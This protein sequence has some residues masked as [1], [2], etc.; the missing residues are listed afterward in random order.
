MKLVEDLIKNNYLLTPSAYY[1]LAP[2][3]EN[4][5]FTL[6]E[7]VKFAK[8][9]GTFVIDEGLAEEFI[10]FKGLISSGS[11]EEH[12]IVEELPVD[13][14]ESGTGEVAPQEKELLMAE[15]LGVE[16]QPI[17]VNHG[18]E[19]LIVES[20]PESHEMLNEDFQ[21]EEP[22][23]DEDET[24][25]S[26]GTWA[27]SNGDNGE[28]RAVYSDYGI[29]VPLEE[30]APEEI[31][32]KSYSVYADFRVTPREGFRPRAA[33]MPSRARV[34][35][36]VRNVKLT[37][38]KV[39]NVAS[40]EGEII[41]RSY[42][43]HFRSRLRKLRRILRDTNELTGVVDIGRLS[44]T[45]G[46]EDPVTIIGLVNSKRE[47]RKGFMF[48]L[49]DATGTVKVFI[50]RD[51]PDYSKVWE[52]LLDSVVAFS[53]YYSKKGL[54]FAEHI[55]LPDVPLYRREKPPLE[56]PV[57]VALISDIHVG[58]DTFCEKAFMKFLEWLN[59][60][61]A[62]REEE[63]LIDRLKYLIIAGD[64]VD[65]VGIYPGQ[66]SELSIPDIF[67]QYEALA[68]LLENVPGHIQMFIGPGNHDAART[69]IPQPGFYEEYAYP[70]LRLKNATI[71][72]NP[73]VLDLH[74]RKFLIAHGRGIEDVVGNVPNTSHHEPAKP[75]VELLKLRHLAPTFGGKVPVAP[76]PEDLLVIEEVP[77]LVQMGHVHV[78]D[79]QIYRGV[80][81]LNSAT[82]QAQT[83]FQ[84]MV[85]IVPTPAKVP[86]V[87]VGTARLKKV[88]DFSKWCEGM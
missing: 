46:Y 49:E 52:V 80:A 16:S 42:E 8:S 30:E 14:A 15:S 72:S 6:A 87:D 4:G 31:G 85:N 55:Y 65:G 2:H 88:V 1:T 35:F 27:D 26:N 9:R 58:S 67:D 32:A 86:I 45:A 70:L 24:L 74:G 23:T 29:L 63:E 3:Y 75:M 18:E 43:L 61:T 83:E 57:Y 17:D 20:A 36:D 73:A 59:G 71:I 68:N 56:E 12:S 76:D 48:E 11:V 53:G 51:N 41:I 81:L 34:E 21:M 54:F 47:T 84:K 39:K 22:L 7:L 78:F 69:A 64:V 77:D 40:K 82:W 79:Y 62:S 19:S 50:K 66:Y 37:P 33:E 44:Y 10:K 28:V 5:A 13:E 60:Y 25:V 38:P